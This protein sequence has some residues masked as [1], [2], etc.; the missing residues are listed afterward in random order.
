MRAPKKFTRLFRRRKDG[1]ERG[2]AFV[3]TAISMV[4]LLWAGA[5]G[6]DIG[7][8]VYGSRQAQ[9]IADT[10]ALDLAR[11]LGYADTL[12]SISAVQSYLNG[13]LATV[14]AN[15]GSNAQLAVVPG[16]YNP[17]TKQFTADGYT[18]NSC[19]P[20]VA[21]QIP[22]PGCNAIEVIAHQSVPQV[23]FGGFNILSGHAG[24]TVSGSVSGSSIAT[25][26]PVADFSIGVY[27]VNMTSTQSAVLNALL[28][29]LGSSVNLTAAGYEGF[30]TGNVTLAQLITASGGLLSSTNIMTAQL[31]AGQWLSVYESAVA[32]DYG[33]GSPPY[34]SLQALGTFSTAQS[35]DVKLCQLANVNVG[36]IQYNCTNPSVSQQG[37]DASVN[38]L[39]LLVTE[40][41]LANGTNGID[42]TSALNLNAALA[43]DPGLSVNNVTLSTVPGGPAQVANGP[44]GTTASAAQVQSTLSMNLT[45]QGSSLGTLRIPLSAATG[46]AT[47]SSTT[48][49][50]DSLYTMTIAPVN[51]SATTSGTNGV[52]L[53]LQG[54]ATAQGT[55]SSGTS[56]NSAAFT[57]PANPAGSEIPPT[58]ATASAGTNPESRPSTWE[59]TSPPVLTFTAANGAN[60]DVSYTMGVLDGSYGPVL[61]ALGITVGG[62]TIAGLAANCGTV[63]LVQ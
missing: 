14:L 4:L 25:Q 43:G 8:S 56:I 57:G 53:T 42:V 7:F 20:V 32:S 6:V 15:N 59:T 28:T 61:Q 40:A 46:A 35:T 58:A 29:P 31:T 39:Q 18:G 37:L 1:N 30:V 3:L 51:T 33:T 62:A 52:T 5:T 27:P 54:N 55:F 16:Y 2:A 44:V 12:S 23:F 13:K 34:S 26:N 50:D 9:S 22:H 24:N 17:T 41:E 36:S 63:S 45:R 38:V 60:S 11:Y 19:Q 49:N 47:L 21:P 48:C 10:A